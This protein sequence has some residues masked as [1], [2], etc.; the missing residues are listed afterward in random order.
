MERE[1]SHV[2]LAFPSVPLTFKLNRYRH[3]REGIVATTTGDRMSALVTR[4]T[5]PFS[6]GVQVQSDL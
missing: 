4:Y 2:R 6:Q 1:K 3:S 5:S